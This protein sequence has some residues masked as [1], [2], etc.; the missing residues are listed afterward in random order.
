MSDYRVDAVSKED[1]A[2]RAWNAEDKLSLLLDNLLTLKA[3]LKRDGNQDYV[4]AYVNAMLQE[5]EEYH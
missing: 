1:W 4:Y 5:L 2:E 3:R